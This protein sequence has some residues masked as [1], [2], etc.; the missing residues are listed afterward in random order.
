MSGKVIIVVTAGASQG[1]TFAFDTHDI[2]LF[3]RKDDCHAC[4]PDDQQVSRHHFVME[5]NPPH[6][7]VRDLGSLHG[8]IINGMK[9]GGR[10]K[11]ETPEEGARRQYPQVDLHDGDELQVGKTTLRVQ[12]KVPQSVRKA[13]Y[14]QNCRKEVTTEAGLGQDGDFLCAQCRQQTKDDPAILLSTL[15][16]Q[17]EL[18]SSAKIQLSEYHIQK[19]LGEGGMGVV[20]LVKH[21][22]HGRLA[23]L[24]VMLS[25]VAV[26]TSARQDFMR[27]IDNTRSLKHSNIVEFLGNGVEKSTFYFLV[28]YCQGGSLYNLMQRRGGS[29]TLTEAGPIML[30]ALEG[31]AFAH[32][33]GFVH[34][35]LKPQNILLSGAEPQWVTKI[36]DLG[37]AK[38]FINAGLSGMTMTGGGFSGSL[39]FMPHEQVV[40]F[41]YVKPVS[42]VWSMGASFY[43][44]L[45]GDFPRPI[46]PGEDPVKAILNG[47]IVPLRQRNPHIAKDVAVV[48][49]HLLAQDP[50]DRYQTA[51]DMLKAL[52]KVLK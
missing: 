20:Y 9:H 18:H 48:I 37:L 4:L 50:K 52:T 32:Q 27:E 38:S 44:M 7:Y 1:K 6:A 41:K 3:G 33:Q 14:C 11:H 19:K 46:K 43:H 45:T 24:K 22:Q 36:A 23:A 30:Q 8:T 29:L 16:Q 34:R 10:Q 40:N 42:D 12:V 35:D 25:K 2:F 31:L 21:K 26:N 39:L 15:F 17:T 51:G 49:D 5:V 28:E 47:D 13:V